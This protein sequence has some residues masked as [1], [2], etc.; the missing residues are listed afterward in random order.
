MR[1]LLPLLIALLFVAGS[2]AAQ[3]S[4]ASAPPMTLEEYLAE[5][6]LW[7]EKLP[8][9][10]PQHDDLRT[11]RQSLPKSW[12][13][14]SG[15]ATIEVSTA[16]LDSA[17]D[18]LHKRPSHR[19][20]ILKNAIARLDIL[21]AEARALLETNAAPDSGTARSK[22]DEI[23][24]RREFALRQPN[25]WDRFRARFN[26]WF[27]EQVLQRIFRPMPWLSTVLGWSAVALLFVLLVWW[28]KRYLRTASSAFSLP[29]SADFPEGKDWRTW[30]RNAR[31][32]AARN[33]Y[34]EAT[35]C[36]YWAGIARL[37][38]ASLWLPD[39]SRTPREYLRL[40]PVGHEFAPPLSDLTRRFERIWYGYAEARAADFDEAIAQLEK[41][42][43]PS[44]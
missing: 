5:L 42:G 7:A 14:Q 24:S 33:D 6:D 36:A 41:L 10:D 40:L 39:S 31:D 34:R 17:L 3:E 8:A 9:M 29:R 15:D 23:L 20:Q 1:F 21:R 43:C 38:E 19:D 2:L 16:W 35:R 25:W 12:P 18:D 32:A 37:G 22:L 27:Q 11:L 4:P 30:L 26:R 28:V 44:L 13:V